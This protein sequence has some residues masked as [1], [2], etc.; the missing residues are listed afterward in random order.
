MNIC[1]NA[2]LPKLFE[3]KMKIKTITN[4]NIKENKTKEVEDNNKKERKNS[5]TKNLKTVSTKTVTKEVPVPSFIERENS[6]LILCYGSEA[7]LELRELEK[8]MIFP[9]NFLKRHSIE[10]SYRLKLV[11]WMMEVLHVFYC[12]VETIFLSVGIM[13]Y[14]LNV[15]KHKVGKEQLHLICTTAIYM[16]SK[17]EDIIPISVNHVVNK[18]LHSK[19]TK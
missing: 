7:Y 3:D 4:E 12:E 18:I 8:N 1:I 16:A 19:Y 14:Y 9:K 5:L 13:D 11:D 2:S 10:S 17:M 6:N 15:T